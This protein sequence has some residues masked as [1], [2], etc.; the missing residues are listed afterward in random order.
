MVLGNSLSEEER[1]KYV[2]R[3]LIPGAIIYL[4]C[5]FTNPQKDKYLLVVAT[6]PKLILFVINS[7]INPFIQSREHLLAC[8]IEIDQ[9]SHNF[10][11]HDSHISCHETIT[12]ISL[13]E[14]R[15]QLVDDISRMK[16]IVSGGVRTM[17]INTVNESLTISGKEIDWILGGLGE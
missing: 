11:D 1:Q 7:Q 6:D 8:Q 4:H 15:R 16:G 17:V 5:E 9:E 10:L 14:A 13:E 2:D 3:R 12:S